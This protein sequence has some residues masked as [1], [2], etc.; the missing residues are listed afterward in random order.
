MGAAA[1][2]VSQALSV[3]E[4]SNSTTD[5]AS[6]LVAVEYA[7]QSAGFVTVCGREVL[8]SKFK[9]YFGASEGIAS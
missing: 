1:A 6:A 7:V 3:F 5:L 8:D 9:E 4:D 2:Q